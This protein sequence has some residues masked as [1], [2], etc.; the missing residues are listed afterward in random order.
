MIPAGGLVMSGLMTSTAHIANASIVSLTLDVKEV[1]GVAKYNGVSPG[2]TIYVEPGGT[3]DVKLINN[4]PPLHDDCTDDPNNFHGLNTTNLHTHGLHVSPNTDSTGTFDADNVFV[5][6][7]P[8][9]QIVPCE[10]VC[11]E[12]VKSTFR[13]HETQYRF[14]LPED[15][16]SGTFW[17]HAH[18]HG[19]TQ[20]QVAAGLA[21]P[22][23]VK[24]RPGIMPSYIEKAE[25]IILV[26]MNDGVVLADPK[27]GGALN[28][29]LKL[30]PGAVQRW[31]II[32][33]QSSGQGGGSFARLAT[34]VPDGCR[35]PCFGFSGDLIQHQTGWNEHRNFRGPYCG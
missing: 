28:P 9:G 16:P 19:A 3:I 1:N 27:G 26:I 10:E 13:W 34:N 17:Y 11:G 20:M 21:G 18:K 23:I 6:V 35:H 2:Q 29:T 24:D 12:G 32:N 5:S 22:I 14:E 25:E 4:L 33:A 7:V 30:R 8:N 15:H 31:R